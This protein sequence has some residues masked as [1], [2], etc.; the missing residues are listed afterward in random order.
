MDLIQNRNGRKNTLTFT[1]TPD[2]PDTSLFH[3]ALA[4]AIRNYAHVAV[5]VPQV[6]TLD[7]SFLQ[8]IC[9]AHRT[10]VSQNKQFSLTLEE[11]EPIKELLVQCGFRCHYSSDDANLEQCV[12][13]AAVFKTK[14][15]QSTGEDENPKGKEMA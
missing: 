2:R 4:E 11:P 5:H 7:F 3:R 15:Y 13:H 14:P 6:E 8:L 10:A 12:W 9:A 1:G